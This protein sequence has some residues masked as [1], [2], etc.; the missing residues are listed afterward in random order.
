MLAQHPVD[1]EREINRTRATDPHARP[2]AHNQGPKTKTYRY[3]IKSDTKNTLK[4]NKC[5]EE[6]THKLGFEYLI[7]PQDFTPNRNGFRRWMH[8]FG[9]KFLLFFRNG[10]G[11]QLRL[12]KKYNECKYRYG[13]FVG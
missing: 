7:A 8:N 12:K 1:P 10:P 11:W 3:L 4:G 6:A 9:V 5:F 13:D 2:D